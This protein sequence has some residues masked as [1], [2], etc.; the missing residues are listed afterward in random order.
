[1]LDI[2]ANVA[3]PRLLVGGAAGRVLLDRRR[4]WHPVL[5]SYAAE[6]DGFQP[7]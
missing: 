4:E 1:L 3:D 6:K 2:L 7:N 5:V